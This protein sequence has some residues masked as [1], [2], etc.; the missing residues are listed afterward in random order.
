MRDTV[1]LSMPRPR[2]FAGRGSDGDG[3]AGDVLR[4]STPGGGGRER[5]AV[6]QLNAALV[7]AVSSVPR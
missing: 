7:S 5:A 3:T 4:M 2:H 1:G 6:I